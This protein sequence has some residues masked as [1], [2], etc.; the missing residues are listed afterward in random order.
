MV[1]I[2]FDRLLFY[3]NTSRRVQSLLLMIENTIGLGEL[4]H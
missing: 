1:N 4:L 2:F 3:Y